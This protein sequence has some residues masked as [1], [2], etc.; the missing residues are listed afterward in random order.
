[1]LFVVSGWWKSESCNSLVTLKHIL[2]AWGDSLESIVR[3]ERT[4]QNA[5]EICV[6]T[7]YCV[8]NSGTFFGGRLPSFFYGP[9]EVVIVFVSPGY[10]D[11]TR[12][13]P[14]KFSCPRLLLLLLVHCQVSHIC[15]ITLASKVSSLLSRRKILFSPR[16]NLLEW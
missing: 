8:L 5:G 15:S 1:M 10:K 3:E 12:H 4:R 11:V 2:M 16:D 6:A 13:K 9:N 7:Y 14:R